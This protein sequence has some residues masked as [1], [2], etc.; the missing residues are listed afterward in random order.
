M[1]THDE[2]KVLEQLLANV[3]RRLFLKSFWSATIYGSF[4]ILPLAA[5]AIA[6]NTRWNYGQENLAIFLGAVGVILLFAI[7]KSL[8][9]LGAQVR[10]ALEFDQTAGLQDRLSSA[11]EFL[12]A[13]DQSEACQTQIQDAIARAQ[14]INLKSTF[15]FKLPKFSFTLPVILAAVI[16]SFFIP[17]LLPPAPANLSANP[18]REAQL[19]QLRELTQELQAKEERDPELK[20]VLQQLKKIQRQFEKGEIAERDVMLQLA[21][22]DENLRQKSAELGTENLEAEMNTIVPQLMSSAAAA[23]M[24]TALKEKKMD[25]A[26]EELQKLSDKVAKNEL[27]KEQKREL[28]TSMGLCASKLGG[29]QNGSFGADFASATEALEKSDSKA[30]ES[31]CKS[32]GSKLG[33]LKKCQGMKM[34]CNKIGNCKTC[35]GQCNSQ[36]LGF[37]IGMKQQSKGKGGLKAGTAASGDP[38]GE[39]NRLAEGYRKAMKISGEAGAGPVETEVETT[40]GQLSQSQVDLKNVAANYAAMAEEAIEKEDIPLSHRYH[41]KRYFQS[42]R[43]QE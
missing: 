29:K 5:V 28:Q 34:A 30:F 6:V 22:L 33:L 24:A 8:S 13:G 3:R 37:K 4:F 16:F 42:I 23:E 36:E 2:R 14:E 1:K 11:Y 18:V 20:D 41:V 32:M 17:P 12:K 38:L 39:A 19:N 9:G 31:A 40:E 35:V 26:A 27:S 15:H 10:S 43:P 7:I 25:K 21:R